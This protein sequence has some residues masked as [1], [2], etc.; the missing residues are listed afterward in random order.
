MILW[1]DGP[2]HG[3]LKPGAL[4]AICSGT[5]IVKRAAAGGLK[6]AHAGEVNQL[7]CQGNLLAMQIM[8][9]AKGYLSHAI[10][11]LIGFGDPDV[12]V[13]GG[14]VALQIPNFIEDIEKRVI[15]H[16][17]AVQR[18]NVR[19]VRAQ[20]GDDSGL[21][22]GAVLAFQVL[23]SQNNHDGFRKRQGQESIVSA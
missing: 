15:Q 2:T 14:S 9:D 11:A 20:L 23:M 5:A 17:Y 12:V 10:A 8:E 3:D 16:V 22:G 19:I 18:T 6:V 1:K 13:L 4:E 7:A 21:I